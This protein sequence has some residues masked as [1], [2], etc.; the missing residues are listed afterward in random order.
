MR[1]QSLN[2]RAPSTLSLGGMNSGRIRPVRLGRCGGGGV[3][4][5]AMVRRLLVSAPSDISQAD[6]T[7]VFETVNR[8]NAVYGQQFAAVVISLHWAAHA[9]AEHGVR[10]QGSLNRQLVD[11][12]DAVVALFWHRMGSPTEKRNRGRSRN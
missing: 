2:G 4:Y 8:W 3:A 6:L 11:D 12:A 10:P 7:T 1:M 9:A 5:S